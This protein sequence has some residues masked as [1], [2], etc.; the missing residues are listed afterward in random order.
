MFFAEHDRARA[1][2]LGGAG[3]RT[4]SMCSTFCAGAFFGGGDD[5]VRKAESGELKELLVQAGVL[6]A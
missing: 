6:T 3:Q 1:R 2:L 4:D 5:T